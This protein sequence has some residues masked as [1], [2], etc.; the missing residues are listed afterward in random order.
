MKSTHLPL[1]SKNYRPSAKPPCRS[2]WVLLFSVWW[3]LSGASA[4]AHEPFQSSATIRFESGGEME[5]KVTLSAEIARRLADAS[6]TPGQPL[7][8][9]GTGLYEVSAS[10]RLLQPRKT[11]FER[12][13]EHAVFT[14]VYAVPEGAEIRLRAAYLQKLPGGYGA[15]VEV[16]DGSGGV[17]QRGILRRGG[18]ADSVLVVPPSGSRKTDS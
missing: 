5:M 9:I 2:R 16:L 11:F 4:R 13:G 14:F 6:P 10:G 18:G 15:T 3:L 1:L 12:V 17:R 7:Q 8:K